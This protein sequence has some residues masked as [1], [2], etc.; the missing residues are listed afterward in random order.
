MSWPGNGPW[1]VSAASIDD[2]G[3]VATSLGGDARAAAMGESG[4]P[5]L[6]RVQAGIAGRHT[7]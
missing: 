7:Q 6:H 5:R 1:V 2:A 3:I 4:T